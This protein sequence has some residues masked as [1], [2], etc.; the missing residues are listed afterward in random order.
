MFWIDIL[1]IV[2]LALLLS[3]VLTW[4]FRW[5][6]PARIDAVGLS[7]LFLFLILLFSMWAGR[8]WFYPWG[9]VI[10][11][12]PWLAVLFIGLIVSLLI[13]SLTTPHKPRLKPTEVEKISGEEMIA[14]AVFSFFFWVLMLGLFIA[15]IIRYI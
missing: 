15:I 10:Y 12:T 6:H 8:V 2:L 7:L 5:R 13:L 4:G 9:P 11:G 1:V 3:S 14:G